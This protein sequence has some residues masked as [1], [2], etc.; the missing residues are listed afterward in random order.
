MG[1]VTDGYA[2]DDQDR[3]SQVIIFLLL[4][5]LYTY[6]PK[7]VQQTQTISFTDELLMQVNNVLFIHS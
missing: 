5:L 1:R 2:H 6:V 4:T 7:T 3:Y